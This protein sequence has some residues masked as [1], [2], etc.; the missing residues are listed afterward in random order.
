MLRIFTIL[1]FLLT[2]ADHWTT[3]LCLRAPVQGW[4]VVEANPVVDWLFQRVGLL[5]GLAIDS[6]VTVAAIA[7]LL[8]TQ[9]F[10]ALTKSCFLALITASTGYAVVN[11]LQ[12]IAALGISPMG[13]G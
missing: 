6:V 4:D 7:F 13:V 8:L 1:T 5:G 3:Y 10:G 9:R 2:S 11:N 12:A